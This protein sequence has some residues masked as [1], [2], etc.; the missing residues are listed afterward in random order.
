MLNVED[1]P[2]VRFV[3]RFYILGEG[4]SGIAINGDLVV[5]VNGDQ[6]TELQVTNRGQPLELKSE[7]DRGKHTQQEKRPRRRHLPVDIHHLGRLEPNQRQKTRQRTVSVVVEQGKAVLVEN[8]TQVGLSDSK[9]DSVSDTWRTS[10][11][12]PTEAQTAECRPTLS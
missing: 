12:L 7:F 11:K 3:A 10:A 8:S 6:V 2:A 1:F 5:V 4:D 9:T